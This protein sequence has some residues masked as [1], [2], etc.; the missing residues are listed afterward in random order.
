MSSV[1]NNIHDFVNETYPYEPWDT[2]IPHVYRESQKPT[3]SK[4]TYKPDA[5]SI[6]LDHNLSA[7][8]FG[9]FLE[10]RRKC[11]RNRENVYFW[12][13][14][15]PMF[16]NKYR[17]ATKKGTTELKGTEFPTSISFKPAHEAQYVTIHLIW[18][19]ESENENILTLPDFTQFASML[20]DSV[21]PPANS[22]GFTGHLQTINNLL[23]ACNSKKFPEVTIKDLK[24]ILYSC[25]YD[26]LLEPIAMSGFFLGQPENTLVL[27]LETCLRPYA[28]LM[29]IEKL[30][31]IGHLYL[32][33]KIAPIPAIIAFV[34]KEKPELLFWSI[35][36]YLDNY[37]RQIV[38]LSKEGIIVTR[39]ADT[40]NLLRTPWDTLKKGTKLSLISLYFQSNQLKLFLKSESADEMFQTYN[41]IVLIH[42][43]NDKML[44]P[45]HYD[46]S[47]PKH[48]FVTLKRCNSL[49]DYRRQLSTF[50]DHSWIGNELFTLSLLHHDPPA[51][52]EKLRFLDDFY[53]KDLQIPTLYYLHVAFP[54]TTLEEEEQN[55]KRGKKLLAFTLNYHRQKHALPAEQQRH[56]FCDTE[57]CTNYLE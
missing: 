40:H 35:Q 7:E 13:D 20:R 38:Q 47:L 18:V 48:D 17:V 54:Q 36:S 51:A 5:H 45:I 26:G 31:Q 43:C 15:S 4:D 34:T 52:N 46:E 53:P 14:S 50:P 1:A 55:M 22:Y 9:E 10:S 30:Q 27:N 33:I 28:I 19:Q 8:P 11:L 6:Q 49:M 44:K 21:I 56:H 3:F 41:K 57:S 29:L 39:S 16:Q 24:T 32:S 2:F 42:S 23:D 12:V 37:A 25:G